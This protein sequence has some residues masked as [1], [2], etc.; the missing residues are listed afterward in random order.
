MAITEAE[1]VAL[2]H[3]VQVVALAVLAWDSHRIHRRVKRNSQS[4]DR[5]ERN[6]K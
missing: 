2:I 3:M 4:L 1:V 5:I 6:G